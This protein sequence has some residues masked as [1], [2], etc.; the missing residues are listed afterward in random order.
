MRGLSS[1][2]L[3]CSFL[4]IEMKSLPKKTCATPST[5]NKLRASGDILYAYSSVGISTGSAVPITSRLVGTNFK[6]FGLGVL[7][8]W[9]KSG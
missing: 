7:C 2:Q 1:F 6:K 8:V 5:L 4:E 3:A 9:M